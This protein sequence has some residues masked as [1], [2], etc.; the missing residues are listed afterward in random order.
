MNF[1]QIKPKC[2][3]VFVWIGVWRDEIKYWVLASKEVADNPFFSDKQHRGNVGEGQ[4][5]IK[6]SNITQ[7]EKYRVSSDRLHS[8]ILAAYQRQTV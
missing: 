3:D 4:L 6:D 1:Q 5:H 2:C 8:G 7:F